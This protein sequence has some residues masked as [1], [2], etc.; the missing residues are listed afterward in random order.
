MQDKLRRSGHSALARLFIS[1][2][3]ALIFSLGAQA[4]MEV[5]AS[6]DRQQLSMDET[7]TLILQANSIRFS[8]VPDI[9]PLNQDFHVLN[10]QESSSTSIINGELSSSRKWTYTLAPKREGDLTI[11]ALTMGKYQT[12]PLTV[13][14]R[15]DLRATQRSNEQVFLESDITPR[16]GPV[17]AQLDYTV[18]IFTSVNFLD[19]AL[20][21]LEVENAVV[22]SLGESRYSTQISGQDYQVIERRYAIFP[23]SSGELQIP[24]LTLQARVEGYRRS[25]FDPGRQIYR[26]SQNHRVR[27]DPP[28]PAFSGQVWLPAKQLKL[29][30]QWSQSP[31]T[32]YVGD[33]LTRNITLRATGLLGSQLPALPEISL[34]GTKLYPDQAKIDKAVI[35]G[36]LQG[37]RTESLA[38]IPTQAGELVLPEIRLPWWNT[39]TQKQEVAVLPERKIQV[40]ASP[41]A[42][43]GK[44]TLENTIASPVQPLNNSAQTDANSPVRL[45]AGQQPYVLAAL[46]ISVLL[47]ILLAA[48]LLTKRTTTSAT[49][50]KLKETPS[51]AKQYKALSKA[52]K[53]GDPAQWRPAL[54][55]WT[56][57]T[58]G[59]PLNLTE[60]ADKIPGTKA[61]ANAIESALYSKNTADATTQASALDS[62]IATWREQQKGSK[63]KTTQG[64]AELYPGQ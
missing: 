10:Q 46:A 41:D 18:K 37:T 22:E 31:E 62:A 63:K 21:P 59:R 44:P 29:Q 64:L 53:Q 49:A 35:N 30:E 4:E 13:S 51:E 14:V 61:S 17:Q 27:I 28:A 23:Q 47:N 60:L 16:S 45:S 40:L 55:A 24:A 32:V 57:A 54:I 36:Q 58:F 50:V 19:A 39:Q 42:N 20:D 34:P 56:Q 15:P 48:R 9:S 38:I 2:F 8:D 26:R 5:R 7:F 12:R 3:L 52:L 11:P 43:I 33:S 25:M 6:V 1:G